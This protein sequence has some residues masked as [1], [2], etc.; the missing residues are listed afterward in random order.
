MV[1]VGIIAVTTLGFAAAGV[2][3][4]ASDQSRQN[5]Y[6][7]APYCAA[8]TIQTSS[9]VLRSTASVGWVDVSKNTGK[10]AHGY[11][12]KVDLDPSAAVG[13]SQTVTLSTS[14]DLSDS[15]N[16]GD[17]MPVL[18]WQNE[19]TRFTFQ[20]HTHDA[21]ENPHHIVAMDLAQ[22]VFCLL[23]AFVFGRPL[24]R[25]LQRVRISYNLER[26]RLPDWTLIVL[27]FGVTPI[28]ALLRASYVVVASGGAGVLVLVGSIVWPF[29]PWV[30]TPPEQPQRPFLNPTP[31]RGGKGRTTSQNRNK[32]KKKLP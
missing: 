14:K 3:S 18:I 10:S 20:G 9:C 23:V 5:T 30:A 25:R 13:H 24:I 12:T 31:P 26:N 8:G 32:A 19:I 11:T 29:V 16:S 17:S 2:I 7:R 1:L 28:A 15:V 6:D 22:V 27:V 21:D 4:L